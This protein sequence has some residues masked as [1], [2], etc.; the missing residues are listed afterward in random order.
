MLKVSY[1]KVVSTLCLCDV[2]AY[3]KAKEGR[4]VFP[5]EYAGRR[6]EE[7]ASAFRGVRLVAER[8]S[9]THLFVVRPSA[10]EK[11]LQPAVASA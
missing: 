11:K 1:D 7:V 9:F 5:K 3:I 2:V 4:V 10:V 8:G 6:L